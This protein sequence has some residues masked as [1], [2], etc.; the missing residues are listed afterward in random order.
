MFTHLKD[1]YIRHTYVYIYIYIYTRYLYLCIYASPKADIELQHA[2]FQCPG[3]HFPGG[4]VQELATVH[5]II[6]PSEG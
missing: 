6:P 1:M 3:G 5:R 4:H 2:N